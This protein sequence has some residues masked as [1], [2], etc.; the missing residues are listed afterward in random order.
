M[1]EEEKVLKYEEKEEK[2]EDLYTRIIKN[3][4][5][6]NYN[7]NMRELLVIRYFKDN[8]VA[9]SDQEYYEKI[10]PIMIEEIE[11]LDN[12]D[13]VYEKIYYKFVEALIKGIENESNA[14]SYGVLNDSIKYLENKYVKKNLEKRLVKVLRK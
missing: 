14:Y 8:F 1:L 12:P 13:E 4:D 9:K 10:G 3:H 11:K 7:Y 2:I 6:E 5:L